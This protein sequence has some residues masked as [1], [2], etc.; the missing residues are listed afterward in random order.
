VQWEPTRLAGLEARPF[1]ERHPASPDA[2]GA[3]RRCKP[4]RFSSEKCD[5]QTDA[6]APWCAVAALS[7]FA[8]LDAEQAIV[9]SHRGIGPYGHGKRATDTVRISPPTA[10]SA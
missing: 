7:E 9:Q 10:L 3:D 5:L 8:S 6:V 1:E 2:A 4:R